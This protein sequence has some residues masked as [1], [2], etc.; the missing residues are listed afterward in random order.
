MEEPFRAELGRA[1]FDTQDRV[2]TL[3][4]ELM[5]LYLRRRVLP[6]VKACYNEA[7]KRDGT[8]GGRLIVSYQIAKGEVM[9]A[10]V[11]ASAV[12]VNDPAFDTCLERAAWKLEV[13]AGRLDTRRYDVRYPIHLTPPEGGKAASSESE[14]SPLVQMMLDS[15]EILAR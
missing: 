3:S 12:T 1:S 7:L 14:V 13:P 8:V 2:G 11:S 10:S 15:A 9:M 6:H 5:V 4:Q